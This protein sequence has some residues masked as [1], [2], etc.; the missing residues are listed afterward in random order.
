MKDLIPVIRFEGFEGEWKKVKL[1][2]IGSWSKGKLLSKDDISENGKYKCIH[3]GELFK[4]YNEI[5]YQVFSR[6]DLNNACLSQIG[7]ILFPDS[8]VT[9]TGLARCSSI[10]AAGVIL[11]GGILILRPLVLY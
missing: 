11:G 3:Y 10:M 2:D 9:P 6:T 4:L 7:D 1:G 5:V 8:D